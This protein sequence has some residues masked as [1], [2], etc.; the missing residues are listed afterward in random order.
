MAIVREE[1]FGPVM[2][3]LEFNDEQEVIERANATE[4]GLA[5]G[6]FTNDLTRG[7]S[8]DRPA[9]GG[10]VLDQS[11]QR[12]ADRTAVRRREAVRARPRERPCRAS[13]TTRSSRASMSPWAMWTRRTNA[14]RRAAGRSS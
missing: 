1:I 14:E 4:F 13:S 2:S 7:A 6:V 8:G 12:H 10:H 11:I 3:V 9:A 5:A